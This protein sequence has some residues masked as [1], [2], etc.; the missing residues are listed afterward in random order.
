MTSLPKL[1]IHGDRVNPL[2]KVPASLGGSATVDKVAVIAGLS[3]EQME[4]LN[5]EGDG[6][7]HAPRVK[8]TMRSTGGRVKSLEAH[9]S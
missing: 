8:M 6:F 5:W 4:Y 1:V 2:I 9:P 7:R 3:D